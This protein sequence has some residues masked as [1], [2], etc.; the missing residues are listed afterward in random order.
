MADLFSGASALATTPVLS[1]ID[2]V[3]IALSTHI[4]RYFGKPHDLV[5]KAIRALMLQLPKDR[6]VNFDETVVQ[7]ENPA[8][9]APISSPAYRLTRDGFT[10]L[11]MGFTGKKALAFKLAYIDAFNAM[12]AEL[13]KPAALAPQGPPP[14]LRHRRWLICTDGDGRESVQ[15]VPVDAMVMRPDEIP[16]LI[17]E[18][19]FPIAVLRTLVQTSQECMHREADSSRAKAR[20]YLSEMTA[21]KKGLM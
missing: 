5:L 19:R 21:M 8:G 4:A 16:Q 12:E 3:V 2:G 9:G 1:V 17:R 7:R 11:A 13:R 15:A 20:Q 18:G 14:S 6:L 10:L